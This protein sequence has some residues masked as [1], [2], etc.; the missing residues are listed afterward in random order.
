M[1]IVVVASEK[2]HEF[3][4]KY[5]YVQMNNAN[6]HHVVSWL[7]ICQPVAEFKSYLSKLT[8]NSSC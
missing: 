5:D 4:Q 7:K 1:S 6:Y 3:Y 2:D 8:E